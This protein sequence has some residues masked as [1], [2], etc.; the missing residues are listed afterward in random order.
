MQRKI[1]FLLQTEPH[2]FAEYKNDVEIVAFIEF[3]CWGRFWRTRFNTDSAHVILTFHTYV[4]TCYRAIFFKKKEEKKCQ[5][6]LRHRCDLGSRIKDLGGE[7]FTRFG[8][9]SIRSR[10]NTG[11]RGFK[12]NAAVHSTARDFSYRV[13]ASARRRIQAIRSD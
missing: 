2:C 13:R 10:A 4:H 5:S 3:W 6:I 11:S 8:E 9:L 1:C 12:W 7:E